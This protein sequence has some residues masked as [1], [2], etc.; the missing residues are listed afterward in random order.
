MQDFFFYQ[1]FVDDEK[2]SQARDR[3]PPEGRRVPGPMGAGVGPPGACPCRAAGTALP[4]PC[5]T[6]PPAPLPHAAHGNGKERKTLHREAVTENTGAD[7]ENH[8]NPDGR[9]RQ[10]ALMDRRLF[11]CFAL[12][13]LSL[14]QP[15][16][17]ARLGGRGH[18]AGGGG[19]RSPPPRSSSAAGKTGSSAVAER[20][21]EAGWAP[22]RDTKVEAEPPSCPGASGVTG[23]SGATQIAV[24]TVAAAPQGCSYHVR[25]IRG[26]GKVFSEPRKRLCLLP[27]PRLPAP[28]SIGNAAIGDPQLAHICRWPSACK[29]GSGKRLQPHSMSFSQHKCC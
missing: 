5:L 16:C 2:A 27:Y 11:Q 1:T 29:R 25:P 20:S 15:Q 7:T 13:S 18:R 3:A 17:P 24:G 28:T 21:W 4:C 9:L 23:A 22:R 26:E 6:P 19:A 10:F 14:V 8:H 12:R